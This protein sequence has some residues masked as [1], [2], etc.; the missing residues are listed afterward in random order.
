MGKDAALL[1]ALSRG[2]WTIAGFRNRDIQQHLY[3]VQPRDKKA[4]RRRCAAVGRKLRLL[5]AHGL[6]RKLPHTHRYVLTD[7]GRVVLTALVAAQQASTQ[8]LTRA[9]AA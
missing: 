3:P 5:R 6:I 8:K 9:L 1:A 4:A 2:E 7:S